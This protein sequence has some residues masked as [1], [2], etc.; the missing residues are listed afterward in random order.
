[1]TTGALDATAMRRR[2]LLMHRAAGVG[3]LGGN[4]G[5]L[6]ILAAL[7]GHILREGDQFVLSKGHAA[8]ALYV[9]LWAQGRLSDDDLATFHR[10]GTRL[11]GHPPASGVPEIPFATGSL[12]HGPGLSA[13]LALGWRLQGRSGHAYCLTSDGE[14]N[15]GSCWESLAFAVHHRLDNLTLIVDA[16]GLQ[17]FGSTH[18]VLNL[19][20]LAAKFRAFGADVTEVDGHDQVALTMAL[21]V[22]AD[23]GHRDGHGAPRVIV[24][25]TIKGKGV[26]FMEGRMEWH[27][28][29]L[30]DDLLTQALA[31]LEAAEGAP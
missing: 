15:E 18:E 2:L 21:A 12:G 16:N 14:W 23:A 17:G 29:P 8:G 22:P 28:L 26:S 1:M 13:G 30:T 10:D 6:D 4:L 20:P 9:A 24:A 3:H 25:R 27:Y 7:F 31:E 5:C 19:E 11:A